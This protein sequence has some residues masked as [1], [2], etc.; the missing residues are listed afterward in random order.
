MRENDQQ[1]SQNLSIPTDSSKKRNLHLREFTVLTFA[2]KILEGLGILLC[3]CSVLPALL[4]KLVGDFFDFWGGEILW[5]S[6]LQNK[7]S[8]IE[9]NISEHFFVRKFVPRNKTFVPTSFCR[10]ATVTFS[11]ET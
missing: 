9:E 4:R 10:R 1:L 3:G 8:K 11:V 6:D 5:F 7:S 2:L